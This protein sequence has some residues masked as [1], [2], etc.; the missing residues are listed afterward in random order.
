[1]A[2]TPEEAAAR[3]LAGPGDLI[4]PQVML[5]GSGRAAL[6]AA[7]IVAIETLR[8]A[9]Q[10]LGGVTPHGRDYANTDILL[11]ALE[12]HRLRE[13]ALTKIIEDLTKIAEAIR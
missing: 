10:A 6:V 7:Y 3:V 11:S 12:G 2:L 13:R 1:M 5:H 8:L 4:V 9:Q